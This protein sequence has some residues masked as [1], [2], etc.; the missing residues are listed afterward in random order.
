MTGKRRKI[1]LFSFTG[2]HSLLEADKKLP[3]T[4]Q[5]AAE[6]QA[7]ETTVVYLETANKIK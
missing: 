1:K 4:N 5:D 3:R 2:K 7:S 6:K